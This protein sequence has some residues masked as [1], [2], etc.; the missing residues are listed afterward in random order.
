VV[1]KQGTVLAL[2]GAEGT[3]ETIKRGVS[4]GKEVVVVKMA[5]SRQSFLVDIPAIGERTV[6]CLKNGG[7]IALEAG[8]TFLLDREKITK[9]AEEYGV[10]VVGIS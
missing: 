9:E 2:E 7:I 10:G 4:L 8:K 5:R 6:Q 1:V 3:D